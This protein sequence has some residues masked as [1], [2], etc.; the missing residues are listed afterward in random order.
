MALPH[1][2]VDV[3][4][5][6]VGGGIAGMFAAIAAAR[7]G[8][9]V[10]LM[11]ER[12]VFGGNASSEI[13]MWVCG[14]A[15]ENNRE[16]G[17]LEELRMV[18]NYRNP[19][20]QWPIW[21]STLFEFVKNEPNIT[22]L[23]N[24]SCMDAEM[25]NNQIISVTGWQMTTQTFITVSAKLF[26]DCS[27][28]SVLAPLTGAEYRVGREAASEFGEKVNQTVAD[29]KTM[30]M[31]CLIQA[32][33]YDEPSEYIAP[34]WV[35]HPDPEVLKFRHPV[36]DNPGENFWYFELGG[37]RD[38]IHDTEK[39]RDELIALALG[40]W[41]HIKNSGE[42]PDSEYWQLDFLGFLPGKRESRRMMGDYIMTQGDVLNE[43]RFDDVVAFGGW[44]LD[45]HHPG[46][47]Y[48]KGHPNTWGKTPAPYGIPYRC[49][50]SRNIANLFFAGRNI[51]MT[52][53]AMSS[54]RVMATCGLLGQAVGTAA[55]IAV[56]KDTT[57]RGVY[58]QYC[59]LLRQTLMYDDCFI[60]YTKRRMSA[61]TMSAALT[62]TGTDELLS[63]LRNGADRNNRTYEGEQGYFCAPGT[64]VTY[65][66]P[67]AAYVNRVRLLFDSDLDR[68]TIAIEN[69]VERIHNTR[70]N[71]YKNT[72]RLTMPG[73]LMKE[74]T[75]EFMDE[76]GIW[77]PLYADSVNIKRLTVIPLG[78]T[79]QSVRATFI[80]D[81]GKSNMLHLFS[82]DID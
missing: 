48:H 73:T 32:R 27:G 7:H 51:S 37:D 67:E 42:F 75:V 45:D 9:K 5:C 79:V 78:K 47:F 4:F 54:A 71:V 57:P 21:D 61:L 19:Y 16:T 60:P 50:Y 29:R 52:H 69:R 26:A 8:A 15:G 66:L 40:M 59:D 11:H 35:L 13:R 81:W 64:T 22:A 23:L 65:T 58:V 17:L 56:E 38:S 41:N 31:S 3:D 63:N 76:H 36:L 43:G 80:S 30:G 6:V 77:Q 44:P 10:A 24:C 49:L 39:V 55:A 1:Q 20:K 34:D 74:Y 53:A 82:F 14:A 72:P 25:D 12:P 18:N 28:D 62:S 2:Y 70:A 46:G 33:R 68:S